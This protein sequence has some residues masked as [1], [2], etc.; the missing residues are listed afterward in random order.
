MCFNFVDSG[1]VEVVEQFALLSLDFLLT[2]LRNTE[3]IHKAILAVQLL[4]IQAL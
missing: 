4:S 2:R 3:Y 1:T